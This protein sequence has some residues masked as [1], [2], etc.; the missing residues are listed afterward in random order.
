MDTGGV[1]ITC[2]LYGWGGCDRL[3]EEGRVKEVDLDEMGWI[4]GTNQLPPFDEKVRII[5]LYEM[6]ATFFSTEDGYSL[7][8]DRKNAVSIG[9]LWWK[10]IEKDEEE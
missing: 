5:A 2:E 7:A 6:D 3:P 8:E 9:W 10:R 1:D 4:R